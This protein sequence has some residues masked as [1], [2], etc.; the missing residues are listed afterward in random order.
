MH[1]IRT[2]RDDPAAFDAA[3][4]RRS[5]VPV[6]ET[7]LAADSRLRAAQTAFQ[8]A[9]ARRNE[10]SKAIGAAMGRGEAD[11]ANALKA[12]VAA[13]KDRIAAIEDDERT[14]REALDT[15][16][17]ALPNLPAADVPD[18][19]DEDYNVEIA[20][21]GT[22]RNFDFTPLEHADIGPALGLDF[23]TAAKMLERINLTIFSPTFRRVQSSVN[24]GPR[25]HKRARLTF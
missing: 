25:C 13:L 24:C 2:I 15:L 16:L 19:A 6:G 9:Q 5:V 4:A 8:Q 10:A 18:G 12:E 7:I 22:P 14:A 3:L 20:R 21:W 11:T 1:D 23:E 17:A